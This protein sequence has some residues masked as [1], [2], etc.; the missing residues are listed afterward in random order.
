MD[1]FLVFILWC[2]HQASRRAIGRAL[3][4]KPDNCLLTFQSSYWNVRGRANTVTISG[5]LDP[6]DLV[7][8]AGLIKFNTTVHTLNLANNTFMGRYNG[9]DYTQDMTGLRALCH[10]LD[11]NYNSNCR[12]HTLD[13]SCNRLRTGGLHLVCDMMRKNTTVTSLNLSDN[14][15]TTEGL[16]FIAE[17]LLHNTHIRSLNLSQNSMT[18]HDLEFEKM[19]QGVAMDEK[20]FDNDVQG[21]FKLSDAIGRSLHSITGHALACGRCSSS[22]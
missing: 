10:V 4:L 18:E 1:V 11:N 22:H 17:M 13:L 19:S 5:I 21:M 16:Y 14:E 20:M 12:I 2:K 15:V 6:G 7:L 8:I 9:F 3:L